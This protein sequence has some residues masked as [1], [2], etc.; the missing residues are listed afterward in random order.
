MIYHDQRR[1]DH[2]PPRRHCLYLAIL[3]KVGNASVL[4][5]TSLSTFYFLQH[6]LKQMEAQKKQQEIILR[7]KNEEVETHFFIPLIPLALTTLRK[8]LCYCILVGYSSSAA[9]E[10]HIR[11]SNKEDEPPWVSP[12]AVAQNSSSRKDALI[13]RIPVQ[14]CQVQPCLP[15]S[16]KVT[17]FPRDFGS[18]VADQSQIS[19]YHKLSKI[20]QLQA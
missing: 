8:S 15:T 9:G 20:S 10:T 13:S 12:G 6:Q 14:R 3:V 1:H 2:K 11:E 7:R 5:C 16:S 18:F 4:P 17:L 19:Q